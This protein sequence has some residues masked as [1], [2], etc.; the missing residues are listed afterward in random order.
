MKTT[1]FLPS[2]VANVTMF[3]E[4]DA[5][6]YLKKINHSPMSGLDDAQIHKDWFSWKKPENA[7]VFLLLL[8]MG[9][10]LRITL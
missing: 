2:S 3:D 6:S 1:F 7:H 4:W 9:R 10:V 8:N 5:P